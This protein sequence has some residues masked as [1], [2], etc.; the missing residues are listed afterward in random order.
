MI[1]ILFNCI[2]DF[3]WTSCEHVNPTCAHNILSS[4]ILQGIIVLPN[5]NKC[6]AYF[7]HVFSIRGTYIFRWLVFLQLYL[8][9][10]SY[11]YIYINMMKLMISDIVKLNPI[12]IILYF[13]STIKSLVMNIYHD[14]KSCCHLSSQNWFQNSLNL[15]SS[16]CI[17]SWQKQDRKNCIEAHFLEKGRFAVVEKNINKVMTYLILINAKV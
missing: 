15:S 12:G 7:G 14:A 3:L 2:F 6:I 17:L 8:Y 1:D 13:R 5:W 16:F 11:I 10:K 9:R 4:L